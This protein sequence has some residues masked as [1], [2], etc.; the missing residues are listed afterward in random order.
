MSW[1][2]IAAT[3]EDAAQQITGGGRS[4]YK[5]TPFSPGRLN[6][7]I[8]RKEETKTA[9]Q[10]AFQKAA[11]KVTKEDQAKQVDFKPSLV[12]EEIAP[13][14]GRRL[15]EY[16]LIADEIQEKTKKRLAELALRQQEEELLI[17]LLAQDI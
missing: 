11:E 4:G 8:A 15:A 14:L 5:F 6:S 13:E 10:E 17:M 2:G 12:G 9:I 7:E 3:A 1:G 16:E